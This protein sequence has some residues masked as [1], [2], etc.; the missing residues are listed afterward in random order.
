MKVCSRVYYIVSSVGSAMSVL[1]GFKDGRDGQSVIISVGV[2]LVSDQG[3][4]I[5]I[6]ESSS[7]RN[8]GNAS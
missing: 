4:M 6:S 8:G 1:A 2:L 5:L 7:S 3:L